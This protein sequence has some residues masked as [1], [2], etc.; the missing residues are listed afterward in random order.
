MCVI[1]CG[2]SSRR[3]GLGCPHTQPAASPKETDSCRRPWG[4]TFLRMP[5]QQSQAVGLAHPPGRGDPCPSPPS[6]S[7]HVEL[8]DGALGPAEDAG[9]DSRQR[10]Q[11]S[12]WS[13]ACP[14]GSQPGTRSAQGT[15][16][17]SCPSESLLGQVVGRTPGD[18]SPCPD[19]RGAGTL[20]TCW[21]FWTLLTTS[22]AQQ[23]HGRRVPDLGDRSIC[24]ASAASCRREGRPGGSG[25]TLGEA[26]LSDR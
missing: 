2:Y 22:R 10:D 17:V 15:P 20:G 23:S 7:A 24:Q 16:S 11:R 12:P 8:Q 26:G 4:R 1:T 25:P 21:L 5:L 3:A 6:A 14:P 18:C 13:Q 9:G 19:G